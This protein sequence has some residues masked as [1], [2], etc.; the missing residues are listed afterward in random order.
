MFHSLSHVRDILD[1][2]C[3]D[4]NHVRPHPSLNYQTPMEFLNHVNGI[5]YLSMQALILS[6]RKNEAGSYLKKESRF[7]LCGL[8]PFLK[9]LLPDRFQA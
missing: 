9:D 2:W 1:G 3:Q 6:G 7:V 5:K 4:Y 8:K